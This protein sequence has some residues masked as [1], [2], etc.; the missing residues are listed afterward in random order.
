MGR[1]RRLQLECERWHTISHTDEG[2]Q[3]RRGFVAQLWERGTTSVD[4]ACCVALQV[5]AVG[6]VAHHPSACL[7]LQDL[8]AKAESAQGEALLAVQQVG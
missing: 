2:Q 6:G 5:G 4:L 3:G 8:M 1:Q 7:L